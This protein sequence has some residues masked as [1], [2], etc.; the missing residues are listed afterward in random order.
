MKCHW[1]PWVVASCLACAAGGLA[2]QPVELAG[3]KLEASSPVG[4]VT[5]PL[6]GAGVR[7]R[8]FFKVYVAALYVPRK[9][10]DAS[11]ILAQKGPRRLVITMLRDVDAETFAKSLNTGL[12]DNHTEAQLAAMK[13]QVD[14][15]NTNLKLSGDAKSG[16]VIHLEFL[17][18]L[19]TRVVVN[20]QQR[21]NPIAGEEFFSA[22]LRIWL[23][24]KPVDADLRAGLLGGR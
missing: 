21:G 5:L 18:G 22:V 19:G 16:D 20:G 9:D 11:A 17:P 1:M 12:R 24:D 2:A 10:A 13:P 15:L 7:T 23:G 4:A 14:A 3:V 6:N 8:A